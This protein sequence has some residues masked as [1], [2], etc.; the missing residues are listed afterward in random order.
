MGVVLAGCAFAAL[1]QTAGGEEVAGVGNVNFSRMESPVAGATVF[2]LWFGP[3]NNSDAIEMQVPT[4]ELNTATQLQ[5]NFTL[6]QGRSCAVGHD[7]V[8]A[9][10]RK[11]GFEPQRILTEYCDGRG[12]NG[13]TA[14]KGWVV[15]SRRGAGAGAGATPAAGSGPK[16]V[17][18]PPSTVGQTCSRD[19]IE[20]DWKRSDGAVVPIVGVQAFKNGPGGNAL[21]FNHPEG[22]WPKG[23]TKFT[24][25]Y[26][27]GGERSCKLKATCATYDRTSGGNVIRR[28]RACTLTIDPVRKRMTE[29]GSGLTYGRPAGPGGMP[30]AAAA[31]ASA[32]PASAAPASTAPLSPAPAPQ[33]NAEEE[34]ATRS[35]NAQQAAAAR[36]ER[37]DY[38]AEVKRV[39]D[40]Q[41]A[42]E[43]AYRKALADREALIAENERKAREAQETWQAAVAAC[44]AGDHSQ[45]APMPQ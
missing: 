7:G 39:A 26:R 16:P 36:K 45:C 38:A 10:A 35:L 37:A 31:P 5:Y 30:S 34:A 13:K 18:L 9:L 22:W 29:S 2:Y 15:V 28:E 12:W 23:Q 42:K 4:A 14:A 8:R 24:G 20:G 43:A 17:A 3:V 1:A 27:E 21:L 40:E 33:P 32:A 44:K 11:Y 41:A 25:I 6:P 19:D